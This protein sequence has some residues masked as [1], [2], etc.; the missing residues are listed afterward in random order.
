M[1]QREQISNG[2]DALY[3][4]LDAF[5]KD[6]E[7]MAKDDTDQYID[8]EAAE[9][10]KLVLASLNTL[11]S[12]IWKLNFNFENEIKS[13]ND[14][15]RKI[16]TSEVNIYAQQT[17]NNYNE[18]RAVLSTP[19]NSLVFVKLDD[20]VCQM[21]KIDYYS[22]S[23]NKIRVA[24][25]TINLTSDGIKELHRLVYPN[26]TWGNHIQDKIPKQK[27]SET[28]INSI[29]FHQILNTKTNE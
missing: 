14:C 18:N 24:G 1:N 26:I 7:L 21:G 4:V 28:A 20:F 25:E 9:R 29:E 3:K 2:F 17:N 11:R 13:L 19:T 6:F 27:P 12:E 22:I 23:Q 16:Q 8:K 15:V 5:N 10:F